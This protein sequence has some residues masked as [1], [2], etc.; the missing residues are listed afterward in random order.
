M[1]ALHTFEAIRPIIAG[2]FR[3]KQKHR[4][5]ECTQLCSPVVVLASRNVTVRILTV[6][7]L[8]DVTT[9]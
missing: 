5:A 8:V 2:H 3:D 9:R 7:E 1:V 4:K 6:K